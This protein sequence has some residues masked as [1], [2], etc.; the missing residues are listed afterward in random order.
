[1]AGL[2]VQSIWETPLLTPAVFL[3]LAATAGLAVHA[4]A[5]L[6]ERIETAD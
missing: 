5:R 3:L 4:Q 1:M 2:A 6:S